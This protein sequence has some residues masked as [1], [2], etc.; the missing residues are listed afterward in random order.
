MKRS[1]AINIGLTKLPPISVIPTAIRVIKNFE[2]IFFQKFDATVLNKEG[3]EK[4]LGTMMPTMEEIERIHER[5]AENPD[6]PLGTAEQ[7]LLSLS[8]IDCLLERLRLWLFMLDYQNLEKVTSFK[9]YYIL[10]FNY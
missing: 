3:I 2:F 6:T 4:I 9:N 10:F 5:Q 7:F 1:Q 8:D